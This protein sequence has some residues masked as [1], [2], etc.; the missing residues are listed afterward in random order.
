[1]KRI[2]LGLAIAFITFIVGLCGVALWIFNR[3]TNSIAPVE[4]VTIM[5]EVVD[6]PDH[7]FGRTE[8]FLDFRLY[9]DGTIEFDEFPEWAPYYPNVQP[10][11]KQSQIYATEVSEFKALTSGVVFENLQS[12]ISLRTPQCDDIFAVIIKTQSKRVK[13]FSCSDPSGYSDFPKVLTNLLRKIAEVKEEAKI[14]KPT[15]SQ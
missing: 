5:F 4:P 6:D 3:P 10:K 1:M 9:T 7:R 15:E 11:R 12:E 14:I 13:V 2:K 8:E